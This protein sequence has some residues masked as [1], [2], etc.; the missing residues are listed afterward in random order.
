MFLQ[1]FVFIGFFP[2][3]CNVIFYLKALSWKSLLNP[4]TVEPTPTAKSRPYEMF[5]HPSSAPL[6]DHG[7][8]GFAQ[9]RLVPLERLLRRGPLYEPQRDGYVK[10]LFFSDGLVPQRQ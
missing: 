5:R 6:F 2:S 10:F 1:K 3:F 9:Q 4:C 8:C 7:R